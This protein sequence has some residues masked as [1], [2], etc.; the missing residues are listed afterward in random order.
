MLK[1]VLGVQKQTTNDG[2][3]LELG[4]KT[5]SFEAKKFS[6]KSWERIVRGITNTALYVSFQESVDL[7]LPWTTL[8]KSN[9]EKIGLLSFYTGDYSSKPPFVYKRLFARFCD[10]FHQ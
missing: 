5:L 7:G 6:I 2:V 10:I 8:I 4:E 3:L 9:L 1:Q